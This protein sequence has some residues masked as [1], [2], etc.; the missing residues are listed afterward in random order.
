MILESPYSITQAISGFSIDVRLSAIEFVK[1][2]STP[3]NCYTV[4][5][6]MDKLLM[7]NYQIIC[8]QD[9]DT[10]DLANLSTQHVQSF[11]KFSLTVII[12]R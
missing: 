2:L 7:I 12:Y 6:A 4:S 9:A 11:Y 3:N 5:V 10:R 1:G 8:V